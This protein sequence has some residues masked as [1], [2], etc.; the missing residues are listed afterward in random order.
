MEEIG[1]KQDKITLF[2]DSHCALHIAMNP[3]VHSKT[4][5]I[6]VQFHFVRELVEEESVDMYNIHTK[7]DIADVLTSPVN[8]ISLSGVDSQEA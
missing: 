8:T 7:N 3:A 4:K 1:H 2:C 5:H 6:R